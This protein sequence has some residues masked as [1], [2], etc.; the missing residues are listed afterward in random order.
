MKRYVMRY[1]SDRRV[2]GGYTHTWGYSSTIQGAKNL[3]SRCKREDKENNPRNFC[4][5]DTEAEVPE[6]QHVPCVY[7]E[8]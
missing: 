4:V 6:G 1:D 7:A 3:I 2:C 8:A 5:Y